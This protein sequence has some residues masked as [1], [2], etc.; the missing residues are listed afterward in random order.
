MPLASAALEGL[1]LHQSIEGEV[2]G[3]ED[4]QLRQ[5]SVTLCVSHTSGD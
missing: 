2:K 1:F 5:W 3:N 4:V